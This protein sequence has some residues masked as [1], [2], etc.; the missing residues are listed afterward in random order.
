MKNIETKVEGEI[1]TIRIN[2]AEDFGASR[3][4]KTRIIA[5]TEGNK[6]VEGKPGIY[7]GVN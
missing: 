5:S 3:T 4:G 2:L 6:P 7:V 1:L